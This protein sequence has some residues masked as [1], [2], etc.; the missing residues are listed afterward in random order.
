MD[1]VRVSSEP[2]QQRER[3]RRRLARSGLSDTQDVPACEGGRDAGGLDG[4]GSGHAQGGADAV[5][6]GVGG[7]WWEAG[8][9]DEEVRERKK[10]ERRGRERAAVVVF[11]M[12]D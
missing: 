8:G 4:G 12:L 5:E 9:D 1:A 2:L 11:S 7:G 3:E 6:S 10:E